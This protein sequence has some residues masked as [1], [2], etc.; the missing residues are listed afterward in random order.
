MQLG[1]N[2]ITDL[3]QLYLG[4]SLVLKVYM[5]DEQVFPVYRTM[6]EQELLDVADTDQWN[7]PGSE[8]DY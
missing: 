7:N 5:G 4:S 6:S 1:N 2:Q 3:G 8:S